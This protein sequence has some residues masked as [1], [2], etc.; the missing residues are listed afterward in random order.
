MYAVASLLLLGPPLRLLVLGLW[1]FPVRAYAYLAM[2][3]AFH[4]LNGTAV[5]FGVWFATIAW[6][7]ARARD[8]DEDERVGELRAAEWLASAIA[9]LLLWLFWSTRAAP[10]DA[11]PTFAITMAMAAA[12][13][14]VVA[15]G[16]RLARRGVAPAE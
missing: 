1:A 2:V 15:I 10:R 11:D 4:P 5:V 12:A 16:S 14:A 9:A 3:F 13:F 6:R 8:D 7:R